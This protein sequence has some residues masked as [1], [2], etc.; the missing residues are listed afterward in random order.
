[1]KQLLFSLLFCF[2]METVAGAATPVVPS[3]SAFD[4]TEIK[5]V[6]VDTETRKS[7]KEDE[8]YDYYSHENKGKEPFF[9]LRWLITFL[10][11]L[12]RLFDYEP[13]IKTTGSWSYLFLL[14]GIALIVGLAILARRLF[15]RNTKRSQDYRVEEESI[16]GIDFDRQIDE[17]LRNRR[18]SDAIR[19][20]YLQV[21][22]LLQDRKLIEWHPHKTVTEYVYELKSRELRDPY[23]TLSISFLYFRYG[24]FEANEAHYREVEDLSGQIKNMTG[25]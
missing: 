21:L 11:W 4:S 20:R 6:Q 5:P 15:F 2:F 16:Y 13:N 10:H 17:A 3:V 7:F 14:I 1:M 22:K 9:L 8:Q 12:S 19:W 18:Y 24:N 25:V 23:R